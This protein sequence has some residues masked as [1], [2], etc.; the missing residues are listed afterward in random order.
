MRERKIFI[1]QFDKDRLEELT[2]MAESFGA[3]KRLYL[4][5]LQEELERAQIVPSQNVPSKVVT[6]IEGSSSRY[7]YV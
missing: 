1:T 3:D 5:S 4:E 7:R 6:M 2:E